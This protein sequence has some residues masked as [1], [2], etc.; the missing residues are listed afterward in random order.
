MMKAILKPMMIAAALAAAMLPAALS[1]DAESRIVPVATD[2][3]R[4]PLL[5][6]RP[7]HR[8]LLKRSVRNWQERYVSAAGD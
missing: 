5:R 8:A 7:S 1:A 2:V 6:V 4:L 3:I